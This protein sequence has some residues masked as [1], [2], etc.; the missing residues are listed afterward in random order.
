MVAAL[1]A[2]VI[3]SYS[4]NRKLS[5]ELAALRQTSEEMAGLRDENQRLKKFEAQSSEM[6]RLQ[7]ENAELYRLRNEVRQLREELGQSYGTMQRV[8]RSARLR[9]GVVS[10]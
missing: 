10:N 9:D 4:S 7:A 2:G 8:C 1:L 5:A 3:F 6:A